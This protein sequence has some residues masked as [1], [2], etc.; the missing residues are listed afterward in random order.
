MSVANNA[1]DYA[2]ARLGIFF[3]GHP[4]YLTGQCVSLVKWFIGQMCGVKDWQAARGHA[5]DFGDTLVRQG[6]ATVVSSPKRGDLAVWKQDGGSYGHIGVVLSGSRV[7]EQNV[8]LPGSA[9][10][11]VSGNR[12]YSS[13]IDPLSDSWR[14]G[15][16]TYYRLKG[17]KEKT[18]TPA[19]GGGKAMNEN[20][21]DA[22]YKYGPLALGGYVSRR[23]KN[24]EGSDVYLGKSASFVITDFFKSDEAKK[25]RADEKKKYTDAIA[26]RDAKAKELTAEKSKSVGLAKNLTQMASDLKEAR[27][28]RSAAEKDLA[29]ANDKIKALLAADKPEPTIPSDNSDAPPTTP[30]PQST[31]PFDATQTPFRRLME[32]LTSWLVSHTKKN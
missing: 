10:K 31:P 2:K 4:D 26:S 23:R 16:A 28:K 18:N 9:T 15:P 5:K 14:K 11:V 30:P 13:R 21:L 32:A 12:V 3:E 22:L 20:D 24:K 7:F 27:D 17:Y 29:L 8:A 19:T 1:D 6:L 25:R